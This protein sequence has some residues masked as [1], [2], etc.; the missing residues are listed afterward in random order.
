MKTYLCKPMNKTRIL[1]LFVSIAALLFACRKDMLTTDPSDKLTF[2]ADTVIF[3]TVFTTIG[4]TTKRLLIYNPSDKLIV[5]SS[6]MLAGG[7]ASKFRLNVDGIP[8]ISHNDIE[9]Q[10]K[11][12]MFLFVEVT[13]DAS[14]QNNPLIVSDSILFMTN[15]NLQDVDLVAWGQDAYFYYP[16]NYS[17]S[18]GGYSIV[19][20]DDVWTNEK[21]YVVYGLLVV[22]SACSLDIM[23]GVKVYFHK[24][25][26][27][28]VY[29]DGTLRINGQPGNP[30]MMEGDR[31]E[32][33]YQNVPGQ[34]DR[35]W[36]YNGSKNNTINHAIIKN[37]TIGVHADTVANSNPTVTINN[38][39]IFQMSG[40]CLLAQGA[41]ITAEN[42]VFGNGGQFC[43][44]LVLGGNY[45]F[46]H[47]T[48]GSY[49]QYGNRQTPALLLN[50]YYEDVDGNIQLRDLTNAYFGNCI[51]MGNLENE[52]GF[53]SDNGA[54][55]KYKFDYSVLRID[56]EVNTS[57]INFFN[58]IIKTDKDTFFVDQVNND[59][60]LDASSP[61]I[62]AGSFNVILDA[63]TPSNLYNDLDGKG[64]KLNPDMGA[65]E[66]QE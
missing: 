28:L 62:D 18:L 34:W 24:N 53:D 3:D 38:T 46:R 39:Q 1:F 52:I 26:G 48:F 13:L 15:G 37:G 14:G 44:A 6:I 65:Y 58:Q 40:A 22:D 25:S 36:F 7:S 2:S 32:P 63:A 35:I 64:R 55:F 54:M 23:E 42:S 27:M 19:D 30:V 31:L 29:R 41:H 51:I 45:D 21:P 16:T 11:D 17:Q 50:N 61:A 33:F 60:H 57:D 4:S 43:A 47:C 56:P 20:C 9:I 59:F 12:S 5:I 49:Y 10:G 8:G 66:S